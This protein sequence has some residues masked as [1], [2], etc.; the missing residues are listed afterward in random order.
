MTSSTRDDVDAQRKAKSR[1]TGLQ[2]LWLDQVRF[3]DK[4]KPKPLAFLVAFAIG[5]KMRLESMQ[6]V[7]SH[8]ELAELCD[9][10]AGGVRK[11]LRALRDLGHLQIVERGNGSGRATVYSWILDGE[12]LT[13]GVT[14]VTPLTA[15]TRPI[16]VS[17]PYHLAASEGATPVSQRCNRRADKGATGVATYP[18]KHP[19]SPPGAGGFVNKNSPPEILVMDGTPQADEWREHHRLRRLIA[20]QFLERVI[21]GKRVSAFRAPSEW[22]PGY[23]PNQQGNGEF[24]KTCETRA[25]NAAT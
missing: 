24:A 21:N 4:L 9:C 18:Y 7:V 22:P 5:K 1:F 23:E 17:R 2:F 16:K 6:A 8:D 3:D 13:K 15:K 14:A 10:T 20:P 25:S 12:V 11:Q 19:F